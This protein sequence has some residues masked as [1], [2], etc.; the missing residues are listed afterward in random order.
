MS[1]RSSLARL[2]QCR[3]LRLSRDQSAQ[4]VV[5]TALVLPLV[6]L[7]L[8]GTMQYAVALFTYCNVTYACRNAARYASVRSSS[9]LSPA[10][11]AQVQSV[12]TSE[13]F[14]RSTITPTVGVSY[15][16]PALAAGSNTV[17]DVVAVS[18]SWNQTMVIPF[19]ANKSISIGTQ[20]YRIITR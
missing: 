7:L 14:L 9:S 18:A 5:E 12:V 15:Y 20:A 1:D 17:G 2:R 19:M 3:L 11:V 4:T 16:T 8:F 13:I 6:F 10:T